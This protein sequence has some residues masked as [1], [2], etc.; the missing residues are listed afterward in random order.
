MGAVRIGE[1]PDDLPMPVACQRWLAR[2]IHW[3]K[4]MSRWSF[5]RRSS[6]FKP[7]RAATASAGAPD[8]CVLQLPGDGRQRVVGEHF[9]Q[10]ALQ[11]ICRG[12]RVPRAG[13]AGC[14]EDSL[15]VAARLVAEHGNP[16]DRDAVRVD[17][18]GAAVGHLPRED[19][20]LLHRYLAAVQVAGRHAECEGRIVIAGNGD[21]SIYLHLAD[22]DSVLS[23]LRPHGGEAAMYGSQQTGT[24]AAEEHKATS[25]TRAAL[26]R[27][28]AAELEDARMAHQNNYNYR[29]MN[30]GR[31]SAEITAVVGASRFQGALR[32]AAAAPRPWRHRL[33][34]HLPAVVARDP[35]EPAT[36][37]VL[38]DGNIVGYLNGEVAERHREQLQEI[39]YAGQHLVCSAL[40]VGGEVGKHFGVRLQIKPDI[41]RRWA[42]GARLSG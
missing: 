7:E 24:S 41:G 4:L 8:S 5:R 19:A 27:F 16:H 20:A 36:V 23:A 26:S 39:E 18:Q 33:D 15:P 10:A 13:E 21:Y 12:K 42:A 22:L 11:R 1:C 2:A 35:K 38:I 32:E 3:T 34:R 40:I 31:G 37:A 6:E 17:V 30:C 14:W 9:Y 28:S 25:N 29:T